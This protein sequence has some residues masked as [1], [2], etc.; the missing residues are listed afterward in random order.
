MGLTR[1]ED[2]LGYQVDGKY[3]CQKCAGKYLPQP[4]R[5]DNL[6][7]SDDVDEEDYL[8]CDECKKEI[9]R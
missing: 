2:V 6:V 1:N 5:E 9:S 4:L 8:F 7:T 3:Y